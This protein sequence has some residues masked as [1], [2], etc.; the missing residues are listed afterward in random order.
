MRVVLALSLWLSAWSTTSASTAPVPLVKPDSPRVGVNDAP[1]KSKRSSGAR[2]VPIPRFKLGIEIKH[3]PMPRLSPAESDRTLIAPSMVSEGTSMPVPREKPEYEIAARSSSNQGPASTETAVS[4]LCEKI[5]A[6]LASIG[7]EECLARN[8]VVSGGFSVR[9]TPILVK[10]YPP[11]PGKRAHARVLVVGGT[12]GDEYSSVS[13]VFKWMRMLDQHHAGMF[14][15]RVSPLMNPDGLLSQPSLRTNANGVDLNR[16]FPTPN[17]AEESEHHWIHKTGRN[18]RRFPG[19][20][21]VSEPESR[22]LVEEIEAF[23]P[24]AIIATHAPHGIVDF[25]GPPRGPLQLGPLAQRFLGTYP[26]SLGNFAGVHGNVPVVTVEFSSA[27]AMPTPEEIEGMWIDLR[28][29][30]IYRFPGDKTRE[31]R[32]E[33]GN[34]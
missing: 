5:S 6:K 14:H 18:P 15:W 20:A 21:P 9:G 22:W 19:L 23:K 25:D 27:S 29:W 17:W 13:V 31:L 30:L 3:L 12:H 4:D 1:A 32:V 2:A 33:A 8:L 11:L 16:N 26:G 10:E 28:R 24:D 34:I 7:L